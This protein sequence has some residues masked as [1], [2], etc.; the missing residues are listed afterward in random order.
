MS[1]VVRPARGALRTQCVLVQYVEGPRGEPADRR[2]LVAADQR[3]QQ[4]CS[5]I[6]RARRQTR[7]AGAQGERNVLLSVRHG[8]LAP[9]LAL[10]VFANIVDWVR[11][12]IAGVHVKDYRMMKNSSS[13]V[14]D[15]FICDCYGRTMH[16]RIP[17][18][19]SGFIN[20]ESHKF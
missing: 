6:M 1:C 16:C 14:H 10:Q 7:E 20:H 11:S 17:K 18:S 12:H 3:L 5:W 19:S 2:L 9:T 13:P 15:L 8:A 4:K